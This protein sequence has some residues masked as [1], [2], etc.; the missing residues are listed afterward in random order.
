[1]PQRIGKGSHLLIDD[2]L[3]DPEGGRERAFAQPVR[4][5]H[6]PEKLPEPILRKE[7]WHEQALF[8]LK[9]STTRNSIA[10]ACGT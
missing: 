7:G 8:H 9:V 2:F 3:I 5:T 1:M 10:F 6:Q 4:T